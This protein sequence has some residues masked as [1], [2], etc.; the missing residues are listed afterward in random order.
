MRKVFLMLLFG[1][2]IIGL[3]GCVKEK[4]GFVL[5]GKSNKIISTDKNVELSIK[6]DSLT[7]RGVTLILTNNTNKL[8]HYDE[9]YVIEIKDN[10]DWYVIDNDFFVNNP[11]WDVEKNSKKEIELN[12][13]SSYGKLKKGKYRII[14]KVFFEDESESYF[15]ISVEFSIK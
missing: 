1:I 7:S 14:K 13:K 3:T 6:E 8:L 11:L 10:D 9:E 15:Y 4:N 5:D 12:W 2:A